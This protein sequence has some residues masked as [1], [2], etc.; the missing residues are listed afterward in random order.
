MNWGCCAR[1]DLGEALPEARVEVVGRLLIARP[2]GGS[3]SVINPMGWR[4]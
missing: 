1:A 4:M 2:V 3:P